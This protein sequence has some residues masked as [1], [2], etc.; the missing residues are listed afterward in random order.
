MARYNWSLLHDVVA[1]KW[2][3]PV[4]VSSFSTSRRSGSLS[5][6]HAEDQH[7]RRMVA[8]PALR[9]RRYHCYGGRSGPFSCDNIG[10][11][12][13]DFGTSSERK[14]LEMPAQTYT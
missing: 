3:K 1:N 2:R 7:Y 6:I 9:E 12:C 11:S 4:N 8:D 13:F 10:E 14:V 5:P